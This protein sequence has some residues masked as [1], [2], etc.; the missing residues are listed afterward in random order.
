MLETSSPP[1]FYLPPDDVQRECLI[2]SEHRTFCEWKGV[3]HYWH[4]R[5]GATDIRDVAWCYPEPERGFEEI[6]GYLA[7]YPARVDGCFVDGERVRVQPGAFYGGWITGEILG[8]FK[9]EPGSEH[10]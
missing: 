6:R 8:P 7:F 4:A 5:I 9:G 2:A 1:G 3:A 10:W